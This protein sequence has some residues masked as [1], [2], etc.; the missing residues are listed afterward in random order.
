MNIETVRNDTQ[1]C[2][3]KIFVNTAGS[4]LMPSPVV[5]SIIDYLKEEERIGGY[6]L[7]DIRS[8]EISEF[9][10][11]AAQLVNCSPRNIAFAHDATDAFTKAL[12]SIDFKSGDCIITTDDDYVSN[13]INFISL[14]RRFG[15][16]ILRCKNLKNGDLDIDHFEQ[17]IKKQKPKLVTVTHIPTNSGLIQDVRSIGNICASN[18]VIY[19]VDACQSV[20]QIPVDV[21]DIK[22]DFL[23]A[24]GRKFL[25]GPRGTGF[26][27]VSDRMLQQQSAPLFIDLHGAKWTHEDQYQIIDDASRFEMWEKPYGLVVGLK[28]A[29]KYAN[30]IGIENI[31]KYNKTIINRLRTNLS[32]NALIRMYDRG[33]QTCNILTFQKEGCSLQEITD[34]LDKHRVYYSVTSKEGALLDFI[35]KD[36]D[37]AIR[38]SPHYFNTIEEMDKISEILE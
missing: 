8:A 16:R 21:Q 35:K 31:Q 15:V 3:D 37:W 24:T 23:N 19:L 25:R 10:Q 34:K 33:S 14:S 20:G 26:L 11:Q 38:L 7:R 6:K 29:F 18:E 36:I 22:C 12:S 27:Y 2:K 4:S 9:Y 5:T 13:H 30:G 17:L 28:E 32:E 1:N